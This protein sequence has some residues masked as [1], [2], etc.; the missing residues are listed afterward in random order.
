M[1][2]SRV[3]GSRARPERSGTAPDFTADFHTFAV[4]WEPDAMRW[5][6]DGIERHQVLRRMP[7]EPFYLILNLAVGGIFDGDVDASTPFPSEILVD[8]VRVYAKP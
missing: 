4:E 2:N 5:Y 3:R 1:R 6:V 7:D 8:W